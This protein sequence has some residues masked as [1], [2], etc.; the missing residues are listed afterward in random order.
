MESRRFHWDRGKIGPGAPPVKTEEGWLVIY[1]GTTP[2][3][4]SQIYRLGVALLDLEK[5]WIVKHRAKAYLLSPSEPY[6]RMGDCPNVCFINSAIPDYKKDELRIYYGGADQVL[7]MATC[8]I[9]E[10][11]EFCKTK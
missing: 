6:E 5:P 9:S 10:L 8:K 7:C 3:C 1:H 4:N 2:L 11:I